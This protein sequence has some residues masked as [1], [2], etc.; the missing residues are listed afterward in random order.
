MN[1]TLLTTVRVYL[2]WHI[3]SYFENNGLFFPMRFQ[4][5]LVLSIVFLILLIKVFFIRSCSS[6]YFCVQSFKTNTEHTKKYQD[7]FFYLK[8]K[9]WDDYSWPNTLPK[10]LRNKQDLRS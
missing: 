6:S 4:F 10:K 1:N 5:R 7:S 8:L 2:T 9:I 3:F